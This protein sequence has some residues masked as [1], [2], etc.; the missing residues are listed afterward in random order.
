MGRKEFGNFFLTGKIEIIFPS[1]IF[2]HL[3][4]DYILREY[5]PGGS[6]RGLGKTGYFQRYLDR[7]GLV[8]QIWRC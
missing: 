1:Y 8:R 7:L 5:N 6:K 4:N 3:N 2:R